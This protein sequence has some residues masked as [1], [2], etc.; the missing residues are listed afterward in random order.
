MRRDCSRLVAHRPV[1]GVARV[2]VAMHHEPAVQPYR[3]AVTDSTLPAAR[4]H[5]GSL[6]G[7]F[8]GNDFL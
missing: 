8:R 4:P 2:A 5:A 7:K 3:S 6:S 1:F